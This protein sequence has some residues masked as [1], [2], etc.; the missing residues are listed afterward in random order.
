MDQA[1]LIGLRGHAGQHG[2]IGP[3]DVALSGELGSIHSGFSSRK[4]GDVL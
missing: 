1:G 2:A 3:E 4:N